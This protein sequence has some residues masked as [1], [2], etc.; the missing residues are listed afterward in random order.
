M[1]L[2]VTGHSEEAI[3]RYEMATRQSEIA[4]SLAKWNLTRA[5]GDAMAAWDDVT[6]IFAPTIPVTPEGVRFL[7]EVTAALAV[8]FANH[9]TDDIIAAAYPSPE[10]RTSGGVELTDATVER[11]AEEAER[12]YDINRLRS[13]T[14]PSPS[15]DASDS[16]CSSPA[17]A[18]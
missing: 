1:D 14:T 18:T 4:L 8:R 11:L 9:G 6:A 2:A 10:S 12:G 13:T 17:D 15:D 7:T 16:G 3:A 5:P